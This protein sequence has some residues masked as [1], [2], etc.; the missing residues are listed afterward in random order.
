MENSQA[1]LTAEKLDKDYEGTPVVTDYSLTLQRGEILGLLGPNGA[2]KSTTLR[3]LSGT[4]AP[5]AG[6]VFINGTDL[7]E[8]PRQAKQKLGYLP[9]I[10]PLYPDLTI[11]EYLE[12]CARLRGISKK[13]TPQAID[14]ALQR[15]SLDDVA[16]RLIAQMSMGYRQRIGIAQAIIHEPDVI[17]LDEPTVGLDP[18]QIT[19][20]RE[21][22]RTLATDHAVLLSSHILSEV[23]TVCTRVQI[24]NQGKIVHEQALDQSRPLG[25]NFELYFAQPPSCDDIESVV[26]VVSALEHDP[27]F[28]RVELENDE[29]ALA[30]LTRQAVT[31]GWQMQEMTRSRESLEQVFMNKVFGETIST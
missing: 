12:F 6:Q 29:E 22:I 20:I 19:S 31:Q 30:E 1:L 5:T 23:E 3:M 7:L 11:R 28:F 4:L 26:G 25:L 10:P 2:G 9:D 18:A 17:I 8:H 15:C 21:L 13:A 16:S 27:G 14:T 24:I